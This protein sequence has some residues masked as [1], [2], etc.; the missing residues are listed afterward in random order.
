MVK[1]VFSF[2]Q[3]EHILRLDLITINPKHDQSFLFHTTKSEDKMGALTKMLDYIKN[4]YKDDLTYTLQWMKIGEN[5]LH[6]SYFRAKNIY[7]VLNK[8]YF[9]RDL[10]SYKIYGIALNP[11]S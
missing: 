9:E 10:N 3:K 2:K 11:I 5:E 8:F 7:E 1:L 6:T 4:H